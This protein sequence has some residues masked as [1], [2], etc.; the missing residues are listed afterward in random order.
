MDQIL[1]AWFGARRL[2]VVKA[3]NDEWLLN[4]LLIHKCNIQASLA[5]ILFEL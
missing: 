5:G 3:S 2:T 1:C 4:H